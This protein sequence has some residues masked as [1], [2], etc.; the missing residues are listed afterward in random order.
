MNDKINEILKKY[1]KQSCQYT[2]VVDMTNGKTRSFSITMLIWIPIIIITTIIILKGAMICNDNGVDISSSVLVIV[3]VILYW[4][5][6]SIINS[7]ISKKENIKKI[8]ILVVE[9]KTTYL[10]KLSNEAQYEINETNIKNV[11]FDD[12]FDNEKNNKSGFERLSGHIVKINLKDSNILQ[13]GF[14][15]DA[16]G[17]YIDKKCVNDFYNSIKNYEL[18]WNVKKSK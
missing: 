8:M 10:Y 7:I 4:I 15:I 2:T 6:Y 14:P 13:L 17:L 11:T 18:D 5:E 1:G 9:G 3:C 12:V 16:T